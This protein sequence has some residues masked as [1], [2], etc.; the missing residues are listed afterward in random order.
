[1]LGVFDTTLLPTLGGGLQWSLDYQP[2]SVSLLVGLAGDFDFDGDVD[3][4]DYLIWQRDPSV[5]LLA[6]WETNYGMTAPLAAASAAVP[7]PNSLALL[8]LGG[9]LALR[10]FRRANPFTAS[11]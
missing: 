10:T 6:D 9:L 5:G 3:G 4:A 11:P 2:T 8:S 7:E 1:V